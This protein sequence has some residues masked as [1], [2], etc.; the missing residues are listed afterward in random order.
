[1]KKKLIGSVMLASLLLTSCG[2]QQ[3][4]EKTTISMKEVNS[5]A[6]QQ[7]DTKDMGIPAKADKKESEVVLTDFDG[8]P[9]R[10]EDFVGQKVYAKFWASW[11]KVCEETLP[12]LNEFAKDV[13]GY[14]FVTVVAPGIAGEMEKEEFIEWFKS[15]GVDNIKVVF[16]E[17]GDFIK[18]YNI[19]A[20]PTNIFIDSKGNVAQ[21]VP[22][23]LTNDMIKQV[24]DIVE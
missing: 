6:A 13:N 14:E 17:T 9:Y 1:M 20:S 8:N 15:K 18:K 5:K 24:M 11:C 3:N 16:D 7:L 19:K 10:I 4:E 2:S 12:E 21:S 22:G 23:E